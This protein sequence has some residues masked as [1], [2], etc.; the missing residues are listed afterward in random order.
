MSNSPCFILLV[1]NSPDRGERYRAWL[2]DDSSVTWVVEYH[3]WPTPWQEYD[4]SADCVVLLENDD[5]DNGLA[6]V[7]DYHR[8][9]SISR[10][11]LIAI[12]PD[13][14][15][16][17]VQFLKAGAV[18]YLSTQ[19]I[20]PDVLIRALKTAVT[21]ASE[22][23]RCWPNGA[24]ASHPQLKPEITQ[25]ENE[26]EDLINSLPAFVAVIDREQRYC[27]INQAYADC[28][29]YSIEN[30]V[31]KR[32][33]DVV[34]DDNYKKLRPYIEQV[35]TG[36][37]VI[38]ET[39]FQHPEGYLRYYSATYI[40]RFDAHSNASGFVAHV[41][42]IH[43]RAYTEKALRRSQD[44]LRMALE[45]GRLGTWDWHLP[46]DKL[47][48]DDRC[49]TILGLPLDVDASL[50][51][52]FEI[53]HE[54]DRELV[55]QALAAA[56]SPASNG[57]Y[58][59]EYR[60]ISAQ[61]STEHWLLAKGQVYFQ[62]DG[63]P[64][65]FI[66][67][68]LDIT[69][70]KQAETALRQSEERLQMVLE[71]SEGGYWDWNIVTN[72]DYFSPQW[73]R[74]LGY[75]LGEFP[76]DYDSWVELIHPDDKVWITERLQQHLQ[77]GSVPYQ[78]EY[79][80][81]TKT[82]Q[83]K[84]IANY[85]KVV[86]RD[87][88]GN[89]L[90]MSGVHYDISDRKRTQAR[91]HESEDRLRMAIESTQLGTW[92]WDLATNTLIWDVRCK[93]MFG[94]SPEAEITIEIFYAGL[95]P[96]DRQRLETEVAECFNRENGGYYDTEYRTIGIKDGVQR[97][98]AARGKVYFNVDGTPQR[99]VGTVFDISE[100]KQVEVE[101]ERLLEREKLARHEAERANQIKDEFL[102]VLSHELRSPLNPI[103][104]LT[105]LLQTHQLSAAKTAKAL[106]TIERNAIL[107]TQLIDDLLDIAKILRGKLIVEMAPVDLS[108]I[109]KAAL[110]TVKAAAA[111]KSIH[112]YAVLPP[113]GRISGDS[114]RI[115][116]IIWNLL[117]NAVKFTPKQGRIDI[118]LE[119]VDC[120]AQITVKDTGKGINSDFLPNLF[121]TFRQEDASITRRYGG[122]GL[123]LA[124][125]R[126][127]VEAHGGTI[128]ADSAG[129][130]QGATFTMKFPLLDVEPEIQ[131]SPRQ[132]PAQ[133]LNLAS[134][135]VLAVD[136]E[137]DARELLNTVLRMYEAEILT[138][139]SATEALS[140][141]ESFQ[142]D[143][144]ISDV[145]MPDVDGYRLIEQIRALPPEKGGQIPAIALTAY[146]REED[147]Q[148]AINSGFQQQVTKPLEP[149]KL[150]QAVLNLVSDLA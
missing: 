35:L 117:S 14:A 123:G 45:S 4:G 121:E 41:Q 52:F 145:G 60:I 61:D 120:H 89:P 142:P 10:P 88:H 113:I 33:Q 108:V 86:V 51:I 110:D 27:F 49:K 46:T 42:D 124:I 73:L 112:L 72:D 34:G 99:F 130:G 2:S 103:L 21:S 138:V 29:N 78:F 80:L 144:L 3:P 93:A 47:V 143:V 83:W 107:Q 43:D 44:R 74:M 134:I 118:L 7:Q 96:D 17:A 126:S 6:W 13:R 31:G 38:F 16:T 150:V 59:V 20:A 92:D 76:P 39:Q 102:A 11:P 98:L 26:L 116:Q 105:Q 62:D 122:L 32:I 135:R 81:R 1:A 79:R 25:R 68:V 101:R 63:T 24:I 23:L 111:A 30:V 64:Q 8:L 12:G 15:A 104:G 106:A 9:P 129:E 119:R 148:K 57:D 58:S 91:L 28:F 137:P 131:P 19:E 69:E 146:A 66:G 54:G 90:R 100:R 40:P 70:R 67:T 53:L 132:K 95:H 75:D 55:K 127:L 140:A 114:N 97:W 36:Q 5:R 48:W 109:V 71:G 147:H 82:G 56:L 37:T 139:T 149:G 115:Q 65:R 50:T 22:S 141:L 136:D 77:D 84:W 128:V 85:G 87:K 125:V 94:L 133:K 18:D